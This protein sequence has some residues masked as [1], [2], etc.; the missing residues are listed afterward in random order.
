[1]TFN[2]AILMQAEGSDA[3]AEITAVGNE[4]KKTTGAVKG[5]GN[6]SKTTSTQTKGL[7]TS[8]DQAEARIKGLTA[9]ERQSA[10]AATALGNANRVAAGQT[11][12]LVAQGN[13][14]MV[15]MMAGQNPLQLAMQ[16]GTQISQVI[17][18]MGA[19]GAFKSL[20]SAVL[21]MLNPISLV[22]IG[23][24]AAGAAMVNWL[25]DSGPDAVTLDDA[26]SD[27]GDSVERYIA[28]LEKA[29]SP[30]ADLR[31]E[32]GD[33]AEEAR[34]NLV[35]LAEIERRQIQR[36][37]AQVAS[38]I[39]GGHGTYTQGHQ[40]VKI[41]DQFDL[42]L[43]GTGRELGRALVGPVIQAYAD[44]DDA[45]QR[46]ISEQITAFE[47][48]L[49]VFRRAA[50]GV[51]GI[52][53]SEDAT[54]KTL[55][56]QL[57]NLRRVQAQDPGADKIKA[58]YEQYYQSRIASEEHLASL[59]TAEVQEQASIY[60]LYAR[61]RVESDGAASS[62]QAQINTL[63]D[64]ASLQ[65]IIAQFGAD[66]H[67]ATVLRTMQERLAYAATVN[68]R[69][70]SQSVKDELMASWDAANGL[71]GVNT[72]AQLELAA[73]QASRIANELAR[74]VDNAI[75]LA[76]QGVGAADRARINYEFREDPMGKAAALARA[77][78]DARTELPDGADSTLVNTVE[79]E[80]REFVSARV[81]AAG[82]TEQLRQWQKAQNEAARSGS[83]AAKATDQQRKAVTDLITGL[84]DEIAIL[85]VTDP[86]QKELLRNREAMIGATDAERQTIGDL[87]AQRNQETT[88]LETQKEVW[89][90]LRGTAYSFFEDLRSSGGDLEQVFANLADR[91]ADMVFQA[92]LLGEGPLAGIIGGGTGGGLLDTVLGAVFP[93]LASSTTAAIPAKAE[94]G[95]IHGAGGPKDDKILMWG[96]NGEFMMNAKATAK[97][98]HLLEA[99]N[100]GGS[101]PGFANGGAIGGGSASSMAPQINILPMN[102]SSVPLNMEVQEDTGPRGQ[103]QQKLVISDTVATGLSG[104]AAKR[105]MSAQYGLRQR[106]TGRG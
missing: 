30:L 42:S 51:G 35:E 50:D 98:R 87:I 5:M 10:A 59:R 84:Q 28:L 49:T 19:A 80:R 57:A 85:Q 17:G 52:T 67:E 41:A 89:G 22:T 44:L 70:V 56:E 71:S 55:M 32:Y 7:G 94:G 16:Q 53:A 8:A 21:G 102:N 1:M 96:S 72:S 25:R 14:V 45:A 92:A 47:Q 20:G 58:G 93:S 83:G 74:A 97:H 81:E 37:A 99:L 69:D 104:G 66:S 79:R 103:K 46:S 4:A 78:F 31:A 65:N 101:L 54:L 15:M 3:R 11:A 40:Q 43:D 88:T 61:T 13:D 62:A 38:S 48:L 12:N 76:N 64:Q 9:A 33:M 86:V 60:G 23:S 100:S 82:Y 26:L 95:M 63:R 39:T 34:Q 91:I 2:I 29:Q 68:T 73:N 106:G 6:A 24:I 36:N 77:E 27:M 90:E 105:Q 18:P 75:S